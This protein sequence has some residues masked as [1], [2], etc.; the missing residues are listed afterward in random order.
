[1]DIVTKALSAPEPYLFCQS[2]LKTVFVCNWTFLS[3]RTVPEHHSTLGRRAIEKEGE[4]R[5][6]K[7]TIEKKA[8]D[9][10]VRVFVKE[11]PC[12]WQWL[13]NQQGCMSVMN[14]NRNKKI[15]GNV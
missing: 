10:R 15:R 9:L 7:R 12:H 13:R 14:K 1:M 3:V 6:R 11:Y 8:V 2:R 4:K 5:G